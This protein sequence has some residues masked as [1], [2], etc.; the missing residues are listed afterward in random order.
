M[1]LRVGLGACAWVIASGSAQAQTP[2]PATVPVTVRSPDEGVALQVQGGAIPVGGGKCQAA[3]RLDLTPGN[4]TVYL[5][6]G[7]Q[8]K[9]LSFSVR[10]QSEVV[11]TTGSSF[12]RGLGLALLIGGGTVAATGLAV[13]Y[14]DQRAK[15]DE[16]RYA[17]VDSSYDYDSP[18]WVIPVEVAG[19]MGLA[20]ALVGV[21]LFVTAQPSVKVVPQQGAFALPRPFAFEPSSVRF[22]PSLGPR[23]GGLHLA[24]SF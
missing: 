21:G 15:A 22:V 11:V 19:G 10:G 2:A 12:Q 5:S 13:F 24:L 8:P 9:P 20:T 4:Y 14:V 3:C 17:D 1:V 18:A 7:G 6:H 23:G 16:R